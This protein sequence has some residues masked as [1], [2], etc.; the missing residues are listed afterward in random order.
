MREKQIRCRLKEGDLE[1]LQ[2]IKGVNFSK[3]LTINSRPRLTTNEYARLIKERIN[4]SNNVFSNKDKELEKE[5][6]ERKEEFDDFIKLTS[7]KGM[8]EIYD[9]VQAPK[10]GERSTIAIAQ[11][12]DQH[13]DEVVLSESV[14]GMNEYNLDIA[15]NRFKT[16]FA[17]LHKLITHHQSHYNIREAVLLFE[18]DTIG[19]WIHDELAQTNSLSPNEAIYHAKSLY[20]SGL[21]YLDENLNVDKITVVCICGNHSRETKRIQYSNF[22]DTNKEYWMYLEIKSICEMLGL[23]KVEF[24]IPKSEMAVISLFDKKYLVAHGHQFKYAG[25]IG[26]IFPSML[27]W[28]SGMAKTLGVE[29]AFIG[30]YHQSIFTKRVIVN[31]SSKGYDAYALGKNLEYE[32]PSQNLILLDSQYGFCS[33]QP[34][35]L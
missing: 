2:K 22:N 14:M 6:K 25:G 13:I 26:G 29:T 18:G 9:I 28:F 17:K 34:I 8:F 24:I 31:G 19:G 30:H 35:I 10:S 27:R 16:H 3:G 4:L 5:F 32:K 23:K 33:Y 11:F 1:I 21:K 20:V 15:T 7:Q 12:S